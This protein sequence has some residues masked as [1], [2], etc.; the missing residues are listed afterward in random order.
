MKKHVDLPDCGEDILPFLGSLKMFNIISDHV[1]VPSLYVLS[2]MEP[3]VNWS[4]GAFG[5]TT[6]GFKMVYK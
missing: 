5:T 2:I 4:C 3:Q 1:M 6:C